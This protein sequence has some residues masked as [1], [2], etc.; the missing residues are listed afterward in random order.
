MRRVVEEEVSA[1]TRYLD[2]QQISN[3]FFV[4]LCISLAS[5]ISRHAVNPG[6]D[7]D[8]SSDDPMFVNAE[9]TMP[10]RLR[11]LVESPTG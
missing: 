9:K 2:Y 3:H 10:D 4:F 7:D 11:E 1:S 8:Y 5:W 6:S